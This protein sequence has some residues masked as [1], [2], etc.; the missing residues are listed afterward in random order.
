MVRASSGLNPP[1]AASRLRI[2]RRNWLL[3]SRVSLASLVWKLPYW[4][5]SWGGQGGDALGAD[6]V[7]QAVGR[8]HFLVGKAGLVLIG[9]EQGLL[10]GGQGSADAA[11][12]VQGAEE[13]DPEDRGQDGN[14]DQDGDEVEQAAHQEEE[15]DQDDQ[16]AEKA[17]VGAGEADFHSAAGRSLARFRAGKAGFPSPF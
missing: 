1:W 7:Q 14:D 13:A 15:H 16:A 8:G 4:R 10:R 9:F 5:I 12:G 6:L 11:G 2:S 3:S 17:E